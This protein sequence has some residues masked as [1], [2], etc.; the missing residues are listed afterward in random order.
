MEPTIEHLSLALTADQIERIAGG[1]IDQRRNP[2]WQV[3]VLAE[4]ITRRGRVDTGVGF[5]GA[6]QR[7]P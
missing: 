4:E 7:V 2:L 1:L 6:A 3:Q 5:G